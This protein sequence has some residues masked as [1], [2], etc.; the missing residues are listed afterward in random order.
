[1]GFHD[2]EAGKDWQYI[3]DSDMKSNSTHVAI[4]VKTRY[5]VR[6]KFKELKGCGPFYFQKR[7][8]EI[9]KQH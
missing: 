5:K 2:G 3:F 6:P 4:N 1:M 7:K 8:W 9:S